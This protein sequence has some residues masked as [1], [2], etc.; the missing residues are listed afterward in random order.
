MI[1][2]IDFA[3]TYIE[4]WADRMMRDDLICRDL[5]T[6]HF[7]WGTNAQTPDG[8]QELIDAVNEHARQMK[9]IAQQ[10]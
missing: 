5:G 1:N 2:A 10:Y 6:A 9:S 7:V 8:N 3:L 4:E